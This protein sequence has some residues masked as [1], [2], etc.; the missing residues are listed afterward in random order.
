MAAGAARCRGVD[1]G[2][3][4]IGEAEA[5]V[6]AGLPEV[7]NLPPGW[8]AASAIVAPPQDDKLFVVAS[9]AWQ[10][11]CASARDYDTP[12]G[13]VHVLAAVFV[14][15]KTAGEAVSRINA[16]RGAGVAPAISA[17]RHVTLI[18]T[19]D[20]SIAKGWASAANARNGVREID[21]LARAAQMGDEAQF[22]RLFDAYVAA[23][24]AD[25]MP[26]A[27]QAG[28]QAMARNFA[29][30][31]AS[32]AKALALASGD[33]E[34]QAEACHWAGFAE[35]SSGGSNAR[36]R[37]LTSQG[38]VAARAAANPSMLA[39][40]L[41]DDACSRSVGG[42]TNVALGELKESLAIETKLGE[43]ALHDDAPTDVDLANLR[44]L[45]G[46]AEALKQ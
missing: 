10:P 19:D 39:R 31:K 11:F 35:Y 15:E 21:V 38:V 17:R 18:A 22:K 1:D 25:A 6:L 41:F 28:L 7:P 45:P 30:A 27:Y 13:R 12:S 46:W 14:D 9:A 23:H 3:P 36:V 33:P 24:P 32:A 40:A 4:L 5:I 16:A 44:T 43:T 8:T 29:G 42:D 20:P 34:A 37:E 26:W 2:A